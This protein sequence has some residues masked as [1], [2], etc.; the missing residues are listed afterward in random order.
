MIKIV[1][2]IDFEYY[3][4]ALAFLERLRLASAEVRLMHVI[5]SVL[6][7]K[8][9]PEL[10]PTHPLSVMLAEHER[11]GEAELLKAEDLLAGSGYRL[12]KELRKGDPA[13]SLIDCASGLAADLIAVGSARKGAWG[14]LF[15]GS[16]TKALTASA[17]QSILVA[18]SPPRSE[19][20]LAAV[21]AVDHSAYGNAC[22]DRFLGWKARGIRRATL[23][24]ARQAVSDVDPQLAGIEADFEARN[25]DWCDRL[26]AEGIA[27]EHRLVAGH[28]NE[29]IEAAMKET[30][31]DLLV[32]GARGHGFWDRFRLGSVSHYQVVATP[33]NVLVLR[34]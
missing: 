30:E 4:F 32:M 22:F 5:E 10:G 33:N 16:V 7:D 13:R 27:C 1:A 15:F 9:F 23:V 11:Q 12:S 24:T 26:R 29:A 3:P 25:A 20:G 28:P 8:S 14:A 31:A 2:G 6:P 34:A 17:E 19:E 21:F 18:K